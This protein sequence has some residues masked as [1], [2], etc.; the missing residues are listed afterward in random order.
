M[1]WSRLRLAALFFAALLASTCGFTSQTV[2]AGSKTQLTALPESEPSAVQTGLDLER[3]RRWP[4][5]IK[6]YEKSLEAWPNSAEIQYGLRR[7]KVQFAIERRYSDRSFIDLHGRLTQTD[8][9]YCLDEVLTMV[10]KNY[11]DSID[12][13]SLIA[14]GTESLYLA[15]NNKMFLDRNLPNASRTSIANVRRTLRDQYWNKKFDGTTQMARRTVLEVCQIAEDEL[16]LNSTAVVLEYVFGL[17]NALDEY[18]GYLTP[19]RSEDLQS[20]IDGEFVGIGIK[21]EAEPE[22]GMLLVDVLPESPA[23]EGGAEIGDRIVSIDGVDCRNMSTEEAASLLQGAAFSRVQLRLQNSETEQERDT[24]LTRR[25]VKVKSIPTSKIVDEVNGIG[26]IRMTGFQK[27]TTEEL[28]V[29]LLTLHRQGMRA[30]IWDLR[31]NPGGLLATAVDVLD[32]FLDDGVIVSTRGRTSREES[33]YAKKPGTWPIPLALLV[34][35]ESASAS[36][37]VAGAI[38]DH[39]RGVIIGRRTYGKWSVQSLLSC[40]DDSILRLTTAKFYSPNGHN[41]SKVGVDPDIPVSLDSENTTAYRGKLRGNAND[42][43]DVRT[44]I[45][46]LRKQLA[47]R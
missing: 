27:N 35:G 45:D 29:A 7:S 1:I 9:L 25:A 4:E 36:E 44:G 21:M 42:D 31:D 20:N 6:L 23:E 26:Y 19:N 14:H 13:S 2:Y 40:H 22:K 30:L 37:I 41:Y 8:A 46:S 12:Y 3:R 18:S 43:L 39:H 33:F 16:Q 47:R 10:R 11:V 24:T 34:D 5:A 15:L 17:C 28:D 38:R 32:R